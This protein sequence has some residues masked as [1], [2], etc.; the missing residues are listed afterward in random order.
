MKNSQPPSI[1]YLI[2]AIRKET[3]T[4]TLFVQTVAESVGI[5][6]TDLKCLDFLTEVRSTTAGDLA[7]ITGLTTGA[8]TAVID[9][10]EK[11]GYI[12]RTA[13]SSDRRKTIIQILVKHHRHSQIVHN[14]FTHKMPRILSAYT[15]KE[16][17][18]IADWNTRLTALLQDETK[19]LRALPQK[20]QK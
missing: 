20:N 11:A 10:M 16:R 7:R 13:D 15:R 17:A 5:H 1:S 3:R 8:I 4:A 19:R 18:I 12:K 6:P 9:R 14:L 2:A